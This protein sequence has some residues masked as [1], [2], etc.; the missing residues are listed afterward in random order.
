MFNISIL[1]SI[2]K[3]LEI[4]FKN[5]LEFIYNLPK[6]KILIITLRSR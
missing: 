1:A 5:Y 6:S 3:D 4:N 2:L